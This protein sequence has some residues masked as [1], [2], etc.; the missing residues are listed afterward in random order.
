MTQEINLGGTIYISS[1]RAAEI[2]GYTQDY[3]GQLA[4]GGQITAQRVS[5]LWYIVEQSLRDYKEKADTYKPEPP[6]P[7][8]VVD[9]E[10][11]VSFDGK[12]YISAQRAAKITG[13]HQDYVG[14]LA[15]SGKILSRQIGNR[16]YVDREGLVEH[17]RHNDALLAAV[18][19]ESVGL[20]KP[21]ELQPPQEEEKQGHFTYFSEAVSPSPIHEPTI[22]TIAN[23]SPQE[24]LEGPEAVPEIEPEPEH[25]IPIRVVRDP[26]SFAVPSRQFKTSTKRY[27]GTSR[28]VA[29]LALLLVVGVAGAGIWLFSEKAPVVSKIAHTSAFEAARLLFSRELVYT[30][31]QPF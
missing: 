31:D 15:R 19:T 13:Y 6:K 17:K 4:R 21:E 9:L 23:E 27:F 26:I 1:K 28:I 12:D 16:W 25:Q 30:K 7:E 22:E 3:I 14:Q 29:V 24:I 10:A 11:S 18:Q 5:G 20:A 8:P 2:T